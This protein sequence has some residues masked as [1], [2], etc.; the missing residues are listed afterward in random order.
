MSDI[1]I[2]AGS[3]GKDFAGKMCSYL[4]IGQRPTETIRFSEGNTY[5]KIGEHV[6]DEEIYLVQPIGGGAVELSGGANDDFVELLFWMDAFKRSGAKY[7]TA[8]IPYFSYAKG[9]KKDEPRVSIRARVIAESI[10]L[11][12]ADRIITMDL[13]AP[14]IQGFFKKPVDHL[15]ARPILSPC[16]ERLGIEDLVIVSPDAGFAKNARKYA[17]SLCVPLAIADK[18]RTCNDES[19]EIRDIIGVVAGKNAMIVDDFSLSGGTLVELSRQ[20]KAK[21]ARR[22]YA[23]LSH[24]PLSEAGIKKVEESDIE[25]LI[26]TDSVPRRRPLDSSRFKVVSVAPL[27]AEVVSRM[28]NRVAIGD[29]METVPEKM[30]TDLSF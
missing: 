17:S 19:A 18:T 23:C 22:I 24:L 26:S 9:D 16:I 20:L 10:E 7:V 27:F 15:F 6:R 14:Q 8:V 1:K 3:S 28:Q 2:F 12:G 4:G 25:C 5:V 29:L 30:L 21:G 13:H 11:A